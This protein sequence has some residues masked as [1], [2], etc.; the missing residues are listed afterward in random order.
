MKIT[1]MDKV[2]RKKSKNISLT[3][4]M[5]FV[6]MTPR[7][8]IATINSL[9]NQLAMHDA[10][11]GRITNSVLMQKGTTHFTIGIDEDPCDVLNGK[12]EGCNMYDSGYA[13]KQ[14]YKNGTGSVWEV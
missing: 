12:D 5:V 2:S 8:A 13:C 4:G 1:I 10:N 3:N 7:E 14:C 6:L 11:T 9:S